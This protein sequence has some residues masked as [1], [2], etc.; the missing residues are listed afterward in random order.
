MGLFKK[1]CMYCMEKI[2]KGHEKFT[3]VEVPG[4]V[5]TLNKPFCSE[6]HANKY[7]EEVRN[8]P[9]KSGGGCCG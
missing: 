1:R 5:G 7:E 3:N 9:K 8:L 4:Y 2:E 6:E